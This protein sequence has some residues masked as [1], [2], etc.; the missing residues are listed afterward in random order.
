MYLYV[1]FRGKQEWAIQRKRKHCAMTQYK[2]KQMKK[3]KK[4][5]KLKGVFKHSFNY[6]INKINNARKTNL[7]THI[8]FEGE[9]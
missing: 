4:H 8:L 3:H 9:T 6:E 2:D 5:G 7:D 1:N